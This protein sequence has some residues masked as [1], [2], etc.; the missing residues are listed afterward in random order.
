MARQPIFWRK[1]PDEYHK[2]PTTMYIKQLLA[3]IYRYLAAEPGI[4]RDS[5]GG[6]DG[7]KPMII[8]RP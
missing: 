1:V 7:I 6:A 2:I 3:I 5:N 4:G 8:T